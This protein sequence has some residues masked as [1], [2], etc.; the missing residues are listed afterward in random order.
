VSEKEGFC[1]VG[2][3]L[4]IICSTF[5]WWQFSSKHLIYIYRNS[6]QLTLLWYRCENY[7]TLKCCETLPVTVSIPGLAI[8]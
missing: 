5:L 2:A 4:T 1:Q 6:L 7:G 8:W 3:S